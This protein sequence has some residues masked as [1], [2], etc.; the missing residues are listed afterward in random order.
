MA[1]RTG[2]Q[3]GSI[4]GVFRG[5]PA[6][7]QKPVFYHFTLSGESK[8]SYQR[9]QAARNDSECNCEACEK[10]RRKTT[11]KEDGISGDILSLSD[12]V[13]LVRIDDAVIADAIQDWQ[14]KQAGQFSRMLA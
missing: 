9:I 5:I 8:V 3:P 11:A 2:S 12:Y 13:A 14:S 6:R 10:K 7:G 1:I 4:I